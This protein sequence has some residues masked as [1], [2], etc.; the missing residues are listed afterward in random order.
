M[1]YFKDNFL[2]DKD[3]DKLIKIFND[4]PA[5]QSVYPVN[6]S[7]CINLMLVNSRYISNLLNS[8]S[9]SV[10]HFMQSGLILDNV[11]LVRWP[12][13][14][15][16]GPH[17]DSSDA[18]GIFIYLNEDFE[19]GQTEVIY[20]NDTQAS[21]T[22]QPKK[23]KALSFINGDNGY[24]HQVKEIT[25]GERYSIALWYLFDYEENFSNGQPVTEYSDMN[26]Y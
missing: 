1:L 9:S 25:K 20:D 17:K 5:H 21:I 11:E 23:G 7:I 14:S 8:I 24:V 2:E 10:C 15:Y 18:C 22:V 26:T 4:N 6:N 16:M 12:T 13:G 3:C 19:G